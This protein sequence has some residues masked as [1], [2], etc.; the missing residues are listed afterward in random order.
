M[1]MTRIVP[2]FQSFCES[3]MS[4]KM[5]MLRVVPIYSKCSINIRDDTYYSC[6]CGFVLVVTTW[7]LDASPRFC[8]SN[9]HSSSRLMSDAL[10]I[11]KSVWLLKPMLCSTLLKHG[12]FLSWPTSLSLPYSLVVCTG[13]FILL[14]GNRNIRSRVKYYPLL[15]LS[16]CQRSNHS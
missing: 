13:V 16:M 15:C 14:T 12:L 8:I 1:G 9:Y 10:T 5:W 4:Y 6:P 11:M 2:T 7:L 3:E